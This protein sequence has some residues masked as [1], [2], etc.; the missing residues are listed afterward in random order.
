MKGLLQSKKFRNNLKKWLC[1]YVGVLLLLTTVITYSKYITSLQSE[2]KADTAKFNLLLEPFDVDD[3]VHNINDELVYKFYVDT[4]DV[5]VKSKLKLLTFVDKSFTIESISEGFVAEEENETTAQGRQ[6]RVYSV[7]I[8]KDLSGRKE[9]E[10]HVK[11]NNSEGLNQ[12]GDPLSINE[13]NPDVF[14][15]IVTIGY[16]MEQMN[17]G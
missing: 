9:F 12:N 16:K 7:E 15:D 1:M 11:Y 8:P 13:S 5:N 2:G 17:I 4:K 10:V 3:S 6:V 14:E